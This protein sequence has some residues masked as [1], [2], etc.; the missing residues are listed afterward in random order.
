MHY[1]WD[2]GPDGEARRP[3]LRLL[4]GE[5]VAGGG[6]LKVGQVLHR[7]LVALGSDFYR[8]W[9]IAPLHFRVFPNEFFNPTSSPHRVHEAIRRLREWFVEFGLP[10]VIE[11]EG[12]AYRLGGTRPCRLII[13][14]RD[15]VQRKISVTLHRLK[16]QMGDQAFS[17]REAADLLK[18]PTRSL[19]RV[20][21]EA[22]KMALIRRTGEGRSTRYLFHGE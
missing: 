16:E 17:L 11:E 8:P 13:P 9:R 5:T 19:H 12:G 3:T 1:A 7:L 6:T 15:L 18:L 4:E 14:K 10:L 22:R 20:L 21:D 2:L